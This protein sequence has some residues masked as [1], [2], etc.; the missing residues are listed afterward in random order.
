VEIQFAKG[1][2]RVVWVQT[3]ND[4]ASFSATLKEVPVKVSIP[5]GRGV[6]AVKR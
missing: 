2:P 3:S 4:G 5:A 1:P 6:L